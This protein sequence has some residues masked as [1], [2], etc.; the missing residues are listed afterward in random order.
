MKWIHRS[1]QDGNFFHVGCISPYT[2]LPPSVEDIKVKGKGIKRKLDF[3]ENET[4]VVEKRTRVFFKVRILI[5][6]FIEKGE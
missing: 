6:F 2:A 4:E 5:G 1:D 3:N